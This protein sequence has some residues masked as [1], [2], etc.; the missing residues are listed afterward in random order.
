VKYCKRCFYPDTKPD[1]WFDKDGVCA[2]CIA[3]DKRKSIDWKVREKEFAEIARGLAKQ[4]GYHCVVP[5][6][7]G[8]DSTAQI[9]KVL[10]YGLNPLAVNARTDDLTPIGRRNLDNISKLG[11]DLV[12]VVPNAKLR[13]S[14]AKYG[15][16]TVGDISWAEH[17]TIFTIPFKEAF[18]RGIVHIFWGENSQNEYGGP[19][20][21]QGTKELTTAWLQEFGGLN[22]LRVGDLVDAKIASASQL[23][24][25]SV[26]PQA[27]GVRSLFLGYYFP[28]SGLH[29]AELARKHGF[30]WYSLC[31]EGNGTQ[32]ENLDNYQ[33]GLHD[34]FKYIKFGFGRA[35]DIA[36][37]NLRR[38]LCERE[39]A[40]EFIICWDGKYGSPLRYL[41]QS[42]ELTVA[43]LGLSKGQLWAIIE[44]FTNKELFE[45]VG[46]G[47]VKPKFL[48]DLYNA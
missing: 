4:S 45:Y 30:E 18:A 29:N 34:Y 23:M 9:V 21:D 37:N 28:W 1:L 46:E 32:Y 20:K 43:K 27:T 38:G 8:K 11:V 24:Q 42:F 47:Q 7:G 17:A 40:R 25:Y 3:F 14:I 36:N 16:E 19:E 22:G 13:R 26:F 33:T 41:E 31:V 6:S 15:L 2:A 10:E 12:E 35:T 48:E 44:K 39:Q 5:V